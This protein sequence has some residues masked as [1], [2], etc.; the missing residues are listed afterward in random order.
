[1]LPPQEFERPIFWNRWRYR[2]K[3]VGVEVIFNGMTSLLN[4]MKIYQLVQN[5]LVG[6]QTD[7]YTDKLVIS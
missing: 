2:I 1:L 5:V 4:F 7:G 6:G 3:N